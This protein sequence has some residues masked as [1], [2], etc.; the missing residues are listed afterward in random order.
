M[1]WYKNKMK[2]AKMKKSLLIDALRPEWLGDRFLIFHSKSIFQRS[3]IQSDLGRI[4]KNFRR[5]KWW[6]WRNKSG[7]LRIWWKTSDR[8]GFSSSFVFQNFR[9]SRISAFFA[10]C[11]CKLL[12]NTFPFILLWK[13]KRQWERKKTMIWLL[14]LL[15]FISSFNTT[16]LFVF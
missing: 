2:K 14:L 7:G 6:F 11:K 3:K 8:K 5:E 1:I 12:T 10:G 15:L 13:E 4:W 9:N 16:C